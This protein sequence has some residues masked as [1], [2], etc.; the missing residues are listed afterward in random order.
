MTARHRNTVVGV[1]AFAGVVVLVAVGFVATRSGGGQPGQ[2]AAEIA[3]ECHGTSPPA[4]AGVPY[5]AQLVAQGTTVVSGVDFD[6]LVWSAVDDV[7]GR[8]E[9]TSVAPAT[10]HG[11][12][13][14]TSPA[15]ANFTAEGASATLLPQLRTAGC[16]VRP[17]LAAGARWDPKVPLPGGPGPGAPPGQSTKAAISLQQVVTTTIEARSAAVTV[18]FGAGAAVQTAHG[19][20]DFSTATG[21]LTAQGELRFLGDQ[22]YSQ[23]QGAGVVYA[24][25]KPWVSADMAEVEDAPASLHQFVLQTE[26]L[27]P[28]LAVSQLAWGLATVTVPAGAGT[29]AVEAYD[30]TLNM[31]HVLFHLGGPDQSAFQ[32]VVLQELAAAGKSGTMTVA[33]WLDP[34]GRISRLRY[35]PP[36]AGLGTVTV[37]LSSFG[38]PV[39]VSAPPS[40]EVTNLTADLPG[41]TVGKGGVEVGG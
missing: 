13:E 6:G 25:A 28:M 22:L 5:A 26:S 23:L 15:E 4:P 10:L 11:A 2:T 32:I 19:A 36:G 40:S 41:E 1:I 14:L 16:A 39:S 24:A 31:R 29:G 12:I 8:T 3:A 7:I 9:T 34:A 18:Q 33:V 21:S 37:D 35:T 27:N 30:A 20:F 38:I 17:V